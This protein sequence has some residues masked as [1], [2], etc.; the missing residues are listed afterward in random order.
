MW[1]QFVVPCMLCCKAYNNNNNVLSTLE[2]I[3]YVRI[4]AHMNT[5]VYI[6]DHQKLKRL[7]HTLQARTGSTSII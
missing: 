4:H 6:A 3:L 7:G 2:G 1:T 5:A